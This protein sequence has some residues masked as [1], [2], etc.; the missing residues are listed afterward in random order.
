ME[1]K[2]II[3]H[4]KSREYGSLLKEADDVRKKFCGNNIF[5]RGIIEFSNHCIR[6][7]AYCGLR[8]SNP[9]AKRYRIPANE[10]IDIA[11]GIREEGIRTVVL[12]SGD[13]P[14][15]TK[16]MICGVIREIRKKCSDA[17]HSG[18]FPQILQRALTN[19]LASIKMPQLSH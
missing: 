2:E 18:G 16:E 5:I 19:C 15:C 1:K 14:G 3:E 17:F 13:D 6:D 11:R 12:Q 8:K 4:L 10:I 9:A 7:C